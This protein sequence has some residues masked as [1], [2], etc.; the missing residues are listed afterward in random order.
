MYRAI[1][2]K[3]L[4]KYIR[5]RSSES[6]DESWSPKRPCTVRTV[7]H[8]RW[9]PSLIS[10]LL[11]SRDKRPLPLRGAAEASRDEGSNDHERDNNLDRHGY[12]SHLALFL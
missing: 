8:V 6:G 11:G 7:P 10:M 4:D 12:V 2:R 1:S 9:R 3:L 5:D